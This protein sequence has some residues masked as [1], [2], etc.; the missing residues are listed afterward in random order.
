MNLVETSTI[1][2]RQ[3]EQLS[4]LLFKLEVE[5]LLLTTGR[6]RWLGAATREVELVMEQI[7]ATEL[8]RGMAVDE[9]APPLGLPPGASLAELAGALAP[10]WDDVFAEHRAGLLLISAEIDSMVRANRELLTAGRRAVQETL[11]AVREGA[12]GPGSVTVIDRGA[13]L[14]DEAV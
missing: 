14:F 13:R 11:R 10:P 3:R 9:L 4:T 2:W 6:E 7:R 5:G 12:T 1:L 8:L